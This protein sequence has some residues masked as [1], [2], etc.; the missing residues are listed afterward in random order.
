MAD[1]IYTPMGARNF[2]KEP[3]SETDFYVTD[4][5]ATYELLKR[6]FFHPEILE[7]ACGDGTMAK[8]LSLGGYLVTSSDKYDHGFGENKDFFDYK[9][10]NGDIVTNPPYKQSLDFVK[11]ALDIT[12]PDAKVA[13]FLRL[14]F[15]EG[16]KRRKLFDVFPPKVVYVFS[17]RVRC[18]KDADMSYSHNSNGSAIA[19]AWFVWD[20][21][22]KG[23]TYLEWI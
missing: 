8:I 13:M 12:R 20:K 16:Q 19:F 23:K 11:H 6:E 21:K 14:L 7:C 3:R 22:Y 1:K 5:F 17:R 4:P 18:Y 15:L 10:W 9:S 2:A